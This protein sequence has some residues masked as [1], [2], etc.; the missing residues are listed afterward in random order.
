MSKPPPVD[1]SEQ[2]LALFTLR[3]FFFV[4]AMGLGLY[5]A[6][7]AEAT[8]MQFVSMIVSGLIAICVILVDYMA[9]A[10]S[11]IGT[12]S[13]IVFGLLIGLLV[14]QIFV[15]IVS[16]VGD[17]ESEGGKETLGAIRLA[18]VLIF[19]YLGPAYILRTQDDLRFI[20]PYVE[21][22]RQA[23]GP[24]PL[25]L[26]TSAIID[27][28]IVDVA[29]CN[30][31]DAPLVVPRFVIEELQKIADSGD[32]ARRER[33]RKG[34]E[35]LKLLRDET[36]VEVEVIA[37]TYAQHTEV[38]RRLIEVT[39]TREGKLVTCDY[40]L[41]QVCEVEGVPS[42]NLNQLAAAVKLSFVAGELMSV[43][44]TRRGE[45]PEQGV[46]YLED[47]TMVVV[48]GARESKGQTVTCEI[49]STIQSSQG[50]MV[51]ARL[52]SEGSA[53]SEDPK[54]EDPAP[55]EGASA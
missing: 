5:V 12:V 51:F 33:G 2:R 25:I 16:L 17:F 19:C 11:S 31:F 26:D 28:R 29:R 48:E 35:R 3:A 15:G 37:A 53:P 40:N 52:R 4:S 44:I 23:Q 43:R 50:R 32:R 27:G 42:I 6:Q 7:N 47:G 20:V 10:R 30:V 1:A 21:F 38:D 54:P 24:R 9:V 18:L 55:A 14:A 34:L 49:T 22:R 8:G 36:G 46:G 13:A 39:R 41:Q 45:G